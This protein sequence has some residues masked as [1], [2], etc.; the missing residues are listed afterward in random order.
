MKYLVFGL[1]MTLLIFS[2]VGLAK[3]RRKRKVFK[4]KY[5]MAGCGLG[6]VLMGS[7]GAQISAGTTNGT[8]YNQSF[9]ISFGTLNCIDSNKKMATDK[10][11]HYLKG[12]TGMLAIDIVLAS[13][14]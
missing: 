5:G 8:S 4:R 11:D 14:T 10:M 1:A 12:N 3:K 6:S 9:G 2:D 13:R 7:R